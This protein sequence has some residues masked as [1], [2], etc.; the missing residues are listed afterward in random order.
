MISIH[1]LLGLRD[2]VIAR[3]FE[4]WYSPKDCAIYFVS[5]SVGAAINSNKNVYVYSSLQYNGFTR[6]AMDECRPNGLSWHVMIA[7]VIE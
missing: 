5:D 1:R 4:K 2:H 7:A 6:Y 3:D